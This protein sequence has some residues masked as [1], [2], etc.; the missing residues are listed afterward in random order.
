MKIKATQIVTALSVIA[1]FQ[2]LFF[3]IIPVSVQNF[4]AVYPF[5]TVLTLS[6]IATVT[7][8]CIKYTTQACFMTILSGSIVMLAEVITGLLMGAFCDSLRTILYVQSIIM[9][10]Y[11]LVMTIFISI[12]AKESAN[13]NAG[14]M[15]V[16][17]YSTNA[18][19]RE[20]TTAQNAP[21]H[22]KPSAINTREN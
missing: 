11:I 5:Y 10:L 21:Q 22:R 12:A 19:V 15:P 17:P 3:W 2:L 20:Q 14:A 7:Y 13:S 8:I 6:H 4:A 9:I 18:N 16:I 1:I